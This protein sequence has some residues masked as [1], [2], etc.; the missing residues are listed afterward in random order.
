VTQEDTPAE[1]PLREWAGTPLAECGRPRY[2]A[3]LAD[4]MRSGIDLR[5]L[6]R[7]R[8]GGHFIAPRW[9]NLPSLVAAMP[10]IVLGTARSVTFSGEVLPA[11]SP[12]RPSVW[13]SV[14]IAVER[15][16]NGEV[17]DTLIVRQYGGP[18]PGSDC[19]QPVLLNP[20]N[21]FL[22]L[23]GDRVVLFLFPDRTMPGTWTAA[24]WTGV[25]R[26]E[27]GRIR[28]MSAMS[29]P[30]AGQS[31]DAFLASVLKLVHA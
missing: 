5:A 29:P 4:V 31:E 9:P 15:A 2:P 19:T 12:P 6:P 7:V 26:S 11:A 25:C 18:I 20:E 8:R 14:A 21:Q 28:P 10:V 22:I 17:E 24:P 30:W 23:P 1:P 16:L 27:G 3:W 13:A